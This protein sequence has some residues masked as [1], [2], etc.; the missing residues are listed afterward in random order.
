[1]KLVKEHIIFEKF[2][3]DSDP[4]KDMGIGSRMLIQRW[5]DKYKN[6]IKNPIINNDLTIDAQYINFFEVKLKFLPEYINF[7]YLS[8]DISFYNSGLINLRGFPKHVDGNI[9]LGCNK[10]KNLKHI[11]LGYYEKSFVFFE[12]NFLTSLEGC[13]KIVRRDFGCFKLPN[14]TSLKFM[15]NQ[16][17]GNF[18]CFNTG[19]SDYYIKKYI[20]DNNIIIGG[21]KIIT[22][23]DAKD[24][25]YIT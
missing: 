12:N 4:I 22:K 25:S 23:K 11:P 14:L 3:E 16:I 7:N 10:F 2:T 13:P 18:I 17:T 21:K 24:S 6:N 1:M 19:M 15:P 5:L 8:G 9:Y 20:K